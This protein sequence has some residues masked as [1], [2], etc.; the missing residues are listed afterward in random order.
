[1]NWLTLLQIT[2]LLFLVLLGAAG[3]LLCVA[4]SRA[5][6]N[7]ERMEEILRRAERLKARDL[8]PQDQ[9]GGIRP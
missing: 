9:G 5:S 2:G 1:M 6:A 7:E 3:Y 8:T 4:S